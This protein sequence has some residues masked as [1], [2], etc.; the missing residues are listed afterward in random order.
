MRGFS[1]DVKNPIGAADG[2]AELLTEGI[3]G[4]LSS[5]QKESVTRIRRCIRGALSLIDD[6]HELARVE[7]GHMLITRAPL[8]LGDLI[9]TIGEEY[10]ATARAAGLSLAIIADPDLPAIESSESRVRQIAS[11][12]LSNAIKYTSSGSVTVHAFRH[13]GGPSGEREEW[14]VVEFIDTGVGIPSDKKELIFEE[15]SRLDGNDKPGAGLG[16]AISRV[17]AEALGG[18]ITVES[19]IGHGSTFTLWLPLQSDREAV[20]VHTSSAAANIPS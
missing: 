5:E 18:Y 14:A 6:L 10:Q 15:F 4:E 7:S 9:C 3:Y 17:L 1:H 20:R 8:D 11:N 2:Y 13:H 12:L 16:L 19:D